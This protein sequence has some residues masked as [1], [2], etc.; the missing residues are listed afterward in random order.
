MES[1]F[2]VGA[3]DVRSAGSSMR[4]AASDIQR[5]AY[6][7]DDSLSRHQRFL[8]DWLMRLEY[9]IKESKDKEGGKNV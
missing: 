6:S 3:E 8:D 1:I 4:T 5:A 2:L 7:I 9:I